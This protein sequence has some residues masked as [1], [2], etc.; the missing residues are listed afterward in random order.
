[1]EEIERILYIHTEGTYEN[2]ELR[3]KVYEYGNKY[4]SCVMHEYLSKGYEEIN[5]KDSSLVEIIRKLQEVSEMKIEF[6]GDEDFI[7]S[8]L[9][10]EINRMN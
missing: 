10:I 6:Q 3:K 8:Y 1:M 5:A 7:I 4:Y 9:Q 2:E